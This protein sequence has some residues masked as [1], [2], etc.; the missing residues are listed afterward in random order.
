M[1]RKSDFLLK[2]VGGQD[3]LVPLGP[4]VR[5]MNCLI[6]LNS[7]GRCVWELLAEDRSIE[8]LAAEIV[9]RFDIDEEKARADVTFF[10]EDVER[11]GLLDRD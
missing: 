2:T 10:L 7:T 1:K 8:D 6:A 4:K 5:D 9:K 3:F 11:F